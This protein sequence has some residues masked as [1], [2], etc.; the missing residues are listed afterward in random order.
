MIDK[1]A[2]LMITKASEMFL[3]DYASVCGELAKLN[4]RKTVVINDLN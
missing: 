2:L 4:K 3:T 1:K